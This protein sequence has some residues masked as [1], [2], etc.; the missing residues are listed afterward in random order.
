MWEDGEP[1]ERRSGASF[2]RELGSLRGRRRDRAPRRRPEADLLRSRSLQPRWIA[3]EVG[4]DELGDRR[5][6]RSSDS[7]E[8]FESL[9]LRF[10]RALV[11]LNRGFIDGA[12]ACVGTNVGHFF[13]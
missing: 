9:R 8:A 1:G 13:G 4:Y 10:L 7:S 2:D 3:G 11:E 6:W 5:R 12:R